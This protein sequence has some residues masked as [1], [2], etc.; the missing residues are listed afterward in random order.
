M[1]EYA[2]TQRQNKR[3]IAFVPT[4]G[5]LHKGHLALMEEAGKHADDLVVSI[6]VNPAQF[7]PNEDLATYPRALEKD[8]DLCRD[9]G[10]SVVFTPEASEIYPEGFQTYVELEKLPLHLC[11]LSRPV[12]FKGIA[13]VVTKLFNIVKPHVAIFGQK[14]FQQLTLIRQMVKDLSF[15]IDIVGVP[16]VREDDG[17]AMSSRNKYLTKAQ[18][19]H[20]LLLHRALLTS[21]EMISSGVSDAGEIV[22]KAREILA[23]CPDIKIDYVSICDLLT[24]DEVDSIN[25]PVLMAIA[26]MLGK[27]RLIDNK[28][29]EF[30]A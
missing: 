17:L 13:T 14:D 8:L 9:M 2:D 21:Q 12:F 7:G 30:G 6:F 24:L 29:M 4:M 26:V 10:A 28:V 18:R 15:D 22:A 20:A 23:S 25:E 27:T 19:P 16:I 5:F 11:G 1:M 3:T